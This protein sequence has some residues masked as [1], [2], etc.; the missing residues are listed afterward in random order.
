MANLNVRVD[1][2]IKE[3]ADELFARLGMNTTTAV[4][5]FLRQA[6]QFGGI[7]FEIRSEI[8]NAETIQA[9]ENVKNG[10]GL[11][12]AFTSVEDLMEDLNADD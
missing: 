2:T 12:K 5:V 1:D 10:I 6:L 8:P 3:Q 9:M 7:P 4:N 11:S